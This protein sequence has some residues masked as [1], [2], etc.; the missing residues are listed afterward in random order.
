MGDDLA[1]LARR[2]VEEIN[3]RPFPFQALVEA[4][5][6]RLMTKQILD[7]AMALHEEWWG[8]PCGPTL[9]MARPTPLTGLE[10]LINPKETP[11][12]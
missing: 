3:S 7:F 8:V 4:E 5:I 2:R 6:D 12:V 9:S 1:P 11:V 10:A